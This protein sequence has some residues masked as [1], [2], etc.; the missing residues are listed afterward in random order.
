MVQFF[1]QL[2]LQKRFYIVMGMIVFLFILSFIFPALY[3][4][5]WGIFS[6]FLAFILVDTTILFAGKT[7]LTANRI[8]P[9]KLSNSDKNNIFVTIN[10]QYTFTAYCHIIDEIPFQFQKRDFSIFKV[11]KPKEKINFVYDLTPLERGEY[12]FGKLNIFVSSPLQLM[13]K[14]YVFC[15]NAT[16]PCYPSFVQMKKYDLIAFSKNKFAFGLKKIRRLGNT[17]EFEQI[18]EY[19]LGD[20]I[21]TINW[22]ATAKRK[23]LMVNQYLDENTQSV[24]CIIDKGRVMQMPFAGLSLLDYA[25]NSSLALSNVILKKYDQAGL[26][27]FSKN[28]DSILPSE[29]KKTQLH[30]IMEQ[31]YRIKT[32]FSESDYSKLYARIK[33]K[34]TH[35]SL[36]ILY[37]NFESL[38]GLNRQLPYLRALAKH[39][40]LVVVFFENTELTKMAEKKAQNTDDIFDKVIA[41]KF[42]FEKRLIVNELTKYGIQSVLTTPKDLSINTINKYLQIKAKGNF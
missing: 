5:V 16:L 25:I 41:E 20:D 22:K 30:K 1:K 17:T 3:S 19:T 12:S 11:L 35:R 36:L 34:V 32:D 8:L 29:N 24:Y 42:S 9:E 4:F 39:H 33:H 23:G 40:L 15:D 14:R 31:L 2:Y 37:T 10:N 13:S 7:K 26:L 28:V 6:L 38:N 21:R 27:T 18:K